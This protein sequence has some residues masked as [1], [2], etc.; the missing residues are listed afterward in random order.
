MEKKEVSREEFDA[1]VEKV[2]KLESTTDLQTGLLQ[3]IDKKI[4]VIDQKLGSSTEINNLKIQPIEDRVDKLEDSN[5]WGWR[6][7]AGALI[8]VVVNSFFTFKNIGG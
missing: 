5:K 1:L 2:N 4:D 7:I 6:A 3:A 8:G